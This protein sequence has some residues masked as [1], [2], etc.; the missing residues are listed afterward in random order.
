MVEHAADGIGQ[1][2]EFL[3]AGG[4]ALDA[5]GRQQQTIEQAGRS[6][7]IAR[8]GHIEL[9]GGNDGIDA[10][11]QHCGHGAHGPLA[12]LVA[13]G[14]KRSRRCLGGNGKIVDIRGYIDRHGRPFLLEVCQPW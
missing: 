1:L 2:G 14:G 5:L 13:R 11:A 10:V 9:I 3:Q 7:R 8:G 4:H 12:L 6:A